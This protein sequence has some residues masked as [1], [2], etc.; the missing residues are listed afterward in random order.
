MSF[1][2]AAYTRTASEAWQLFIR[3]RFESLPDQELP[4]GGPGARLQMLELELDVLHKYTAIARQRRNAATSAGRL[5][6][7][8]L[9]EIF[10]YAQEDWKP[11]RRRGKISTPDPSL[12]DLGWLN[13]TH[14]CSLWRKVAL[15]APQLW[16]TISCTRFS[17]RAATVL[18]RRSERLPLSLHVVEPYKLNEARS[19][20]INSWLSRPVLSRVE[21]LIVQSDTALINGWIT[22]LCSP[23]PLLH[24]MIMKNR[25]STGPVIL[26]EQILA[27]EHPPALRRLRLNGCL[28]TWNSPLFSKDLT[29][30]EL[31]LPRMVTG[32]TVLLPE[33]P[34][35]RNIVASMTALQTL[36]LQD[37]YL[38][39]PENQTGALP[40]TFPPG[41]KEFEMHVHNSAPSIFLSLYGKIWDTFH[42]PATS[43]IATEINFHRVSAA[44]GPVTELDPNGDLILRPLRELDAHSYPV[45]GLKITS[46]TRLALYYAVGSPQTLASPLNLSENDLGDWAFESKG[47]RRVYASGDLASFVRFLSLDHLRAISLSSDAMAL[48]DTSNF[49]RDYFPQLQD[50]RRI[51]IPYLSGLQLFYALAHVQSTDDTFPLFPRL[52]R[53]VLHTGGTPPKTMGDYHAALDMALLEFLDVRRDKD[54]PLEGVFVDRALE[55]LDVWGDVRCGT[56]VTFV[57]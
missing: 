48:Y 26:P 3:S 6:A 45:Q 15:G 11:Q 37:I 21:R 24:I 32:D 34:T 25:D 38:R 14:T 41:F 18:L 7:E 30:L 27:G 35:F 50:V 17:P 12:Y 52:Q 46:K 40:Y 2:P 44:L 55:D 42:F 51:S 5:P 10:L 56:P 4:G 8:V 19:F 57:N 39:T 43:K 22:S 33:L 36:K 31:A 1:D 53:I 20:I 28:P 9:T 49:W 13:I 23:M 54:L 29:H 16:T 47:R